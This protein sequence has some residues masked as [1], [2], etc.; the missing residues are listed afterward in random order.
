MND[1]KFCELVEG[2]ADGSLDDEASRE[3]RMR[4]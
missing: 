1:E 4:I 2:Y 3:L